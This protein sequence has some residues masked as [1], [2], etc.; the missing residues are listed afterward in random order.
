[1]YAAGV[2]T[3]S[4]NSGLV[5]GIAAVKKQLKPGTNLQRA[6]SLALYSFIGF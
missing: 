5:P 6:A 2:K 1:M 3:I 4:K